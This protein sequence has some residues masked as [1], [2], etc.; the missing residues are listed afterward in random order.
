MNRDQVTVKGVSA[1][2]DSSTQTFYV[3]AKRS[4]INKIFTEKYNNVYELMQIN[5]DYHDIKA[6]TE[7]YY[8]KQHMAE[9]AA[10]TEFSFHNALDNV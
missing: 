5:I 1:R 7:H 10:G 2:Y 3:S 4:E 9:S 6:N 8:F